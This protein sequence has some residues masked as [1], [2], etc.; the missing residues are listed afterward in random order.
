MYYTTKLSPSVFQPVSL[1]LTK[2][3]GQTPTMLLTTLTS[4]GIDTSPVMIAS[5]R[6]ERDINQSRCTAPFKRMIINSVIEKGSKDPKTE[7]DT[8]SMQ[9]FKRRR[10]NTGYL[11][12]CSCTH[13]PN[14]RPDCRP[15][16]A[17]NQKQQ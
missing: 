9:S 13:F 3:R 17:T 1:R 11:L 5:L 6:L 16:H 15:T 14:I 7:E 2:L 10:S 4:D 12:A 8:F